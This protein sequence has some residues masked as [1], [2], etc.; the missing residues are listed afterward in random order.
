MT[1]EALLP[2]I[3]QV[4]GPFKHLYIVGI[5]AD[6]IT[7]NTKR[8]VNDVGDIPTQKLIEESLK[9]DSD[10]Y[11][12][13]VVNADQYKDRSFNRM[14]YILGAEDS[15]TDIYGHTFHNR[16]LT[17]NMKYF[18]RIFSISSTEEV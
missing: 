18:C 10:Y 8:A 9:N 16:R 3:S 4:N 17:A 5:N 7:S 14:G 15:T 11:I 13:A 1:F 6:A 12:A 2:N